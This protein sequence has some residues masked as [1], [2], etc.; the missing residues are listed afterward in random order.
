MGAWGGHKNGQIPASA[1]G[2]VEGHLFEAKA[3]KSMAAA[4]AEVRAKGIKIHINEGYRP[5]GVPGDAK[6]RNESQTASGKSS[7][8]FQYGRMQRGETPTAA[9]PGGSVHGWGLA[10]DVS[11]G[12]DN[13]TVNSI[14]N[15]HGFTFDIP[16]ESWHCSFGGGSGA[17]LAPKAPAV[18]IDKWKKIQTMLKA[19]YGYTGAIDGI[20][21]PKT[22]TA[23]QKWLKAKFGYAGVVDGEPGPMT[24]AAFDKALKT[25]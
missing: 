6:V 11:P 15:K 16:S 8:W 4:L 5:L 7:Q 1:M 21:G 23:A 19:S 10:A 22:W 3:A 24:Y 20:P 25:I 9:Y 17:T 12:R 18:S 2:N 13:A 14:F